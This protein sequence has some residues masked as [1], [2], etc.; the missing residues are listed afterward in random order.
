MAGDI[1]DIDVPNMLQFITDGFQGF[2][3]D[4]TPLQFIVGS[5]MEPTAILVSRSIVIN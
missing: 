4:Y 2:I 1:V 5:A 3:M